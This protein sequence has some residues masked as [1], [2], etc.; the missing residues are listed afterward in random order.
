VVIEVESD[1]SEGRVNPSA[2]MTDRDTA[3][4]V[5]RF[6]EFSVISR[7]RDRTIVTRL[8]GFYLIA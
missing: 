2:P 4:S 6:S 5:W 3:K 8:R 1:V 7:R